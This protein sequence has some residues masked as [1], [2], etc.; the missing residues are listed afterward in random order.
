MDCQPKSSPLMADSVVALLPGL[1]AVKH[2]RGYTASRTPFE[3]PMAVTNRVGRR[4][5][6]FRR[7]PWLPSA[8]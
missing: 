2:T 7:R 1:S 8:A 5:L 4:L 3:P 6:T